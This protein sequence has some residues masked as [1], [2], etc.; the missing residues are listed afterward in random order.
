MPTN[1][2]GNN[3]MSILDKP[4]SDVSPMRFLAITAAAVFLAEAAVML[5]LALLPPLPRIQVALMDAALL[6]AL[7]FPA[8]YF[9]QLRPLKKQ[10]K[11]RQKAEAALIKSNELL[12][13]F[14]SISHILLAYMDPEFN[15]IRVNQAYAESDGQTPDYFPGKNHFELYAQEENEAIFRR[16]VETGE[17]YFTYAK[18]FEYSLHPERGT[19]YWDW[20]LLPIRDAGQKI[21]G[22]IL[23]LVN[24]TERKRAEEEIRQRNLE[25]LALNTINTAMSSSLQL[26]QV[27][28]TLEQ[29]LVDQLGFPAGATFFYEQADDSL[30]LETAWGLKDETLEALAVFPATSLENVGVIR[31]K[32]VYITHDFARFSSP[33]AAGLDSTQFDC[34]A[35]FSIPLVAKGE[36]MGILDL[37]RRRSQDD[38][39]LLSEGSTRLS[40]YQASFFQ[41]LGNE[42]GLAIH[43]ARLYAAERHA[44]Q[45]AETLR[46]ASLALSQTLDLDTVANTL[47]DYLSKLVPYDSASVL[48]LEDEL[49][50]AVKACRGSD[51]TP[52]SRVTQGMI[53]DPEDEAHMEAV[54]RKKESLLISDTYH[55]REWDRSGHWQDVRNW[56]GVPL[57]VGDRVIGI[58]SLEKTEAEF[59]IQEYL[60]LAEALVSQAAVTIQNAWLF[61]QLQAGRER[62]QS[63]S[64]RLVEIQENE[65]SYVAREL[66]DEAAQA[67][68]SLMVGLRLLEREALNPE[69]VV[70]GVA[71]LKKTLQGVLGDLHRL[72]RDLR[73]ASLDQLGLATTLRQYLQGISDK[74]GLVVQF[75]TLGIPERLPN[76]IETAL[77]RIIQEALNNV[78]RHSHATRVDVLLEERGDKVLAIVEDNGVGF[79]PVAALKSGQLGLL[80]MRE[81]AEMLGGELVVECEDK[82]GT[83]VIVEMPNVD[84]NSDRG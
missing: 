28:A 64:R 78:I 21:V 12:E 52:D 37:F 34:D 59:F 62:L 75:E 48:L 10:I 2:N 56:L 22:V 20:S 16:V 82:G 6:T 25:L 84:S 1:S 3:A 66:H 45:T 27:L 41:A 47:L 36:I 57:I 61:E 63:L 42:V 5:L 7:V 19:S 74:H 43:N 30:T 49:H 4:E 17:P 31:E 32:K 81:R 77:Y 58:C 26:S 76:A 51:H 24:V 11:E 83:T 8:L 23:S 68:T 70:A 60:K 38:H 35:Y 80:G 72:A 29:I 33:L 65:R 53:L 55:Y 9:D 69:G 54:L 13:R 44:R 79:D 71:D 14:F 46:S 50:L 39:H 18:P 73:P 15:F 67:L 40:P